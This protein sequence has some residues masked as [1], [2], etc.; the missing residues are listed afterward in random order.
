MGDLH[1]LVGRTVSHY[2]ILEKL[3]GGGMGVV[4]KAL[5]TKL[6]RMV[7]L[8]FLPPHLSTRAGA[9]ARFIHEAKAA[10]ALDHTNICT[11]YDIDE[12]DSGQLFIVMACYA[13][14]TLKKKIERG[15]LPVEDAL[16]YALQVAEGLGRAHE[17]G[18]VHRDIKPANVLVTERGV[19]K[20]VDF[21]IAKVL[22]R[23]QLTQTGATVGTVSYM[24]PEQARGE[25]VDARSDLWSLG[26][27]LYERLTGER[28][29]KGDYEQAVIYSILNVD[30]E[31]LTALRPAVPEALAQVV[32]KMLHKEPDARYQQVDDMRVDLTA[33]Q[34]AEGARIS[35]T[36]YRTAEAAKTASVKPRVLF[37]GLALFMLLAMAAVFYLMRGDEPQGAVEIERKRLVVLPFENIGP[38]EDEYFADGLTDEI[39][40]RLALVYGLGVISRASAVQYKNTNKTSKQIKEELD[41]DY[42]LAGTVGWDKSSDGMSRLH[43][44]PQLIRTSDDTHVWAERYD[45]ELEQLFDIQ[46]DIAEQVVKQL[47]IQLM[48]PARQALNAKPTRNLEAYDY[49]LRGNEHYRLGE[50]FSDEKELDQAVEM[51]QKAIEL[52][53][54]FAQAYL[55]LAYTHSWLCYTNDQTDERRAKARAAIDKA[56]EIQPD[57]PYVQMGLVSYYIYCL[58]DYDRA[59]EA[60]EN[61]R[62]AIPSATPYMMATILR[63]QGKWQESV[64]AMEET[65]ALNPNWAAPALN[66]AASYMWLRQYR[67]A[68]QWYDRALSIRPGYT[69][70]P[71][72]KYKNHLLWKGSAEDLRTSLQTIQRGPF[73][74]FQLHTI[75]LLERR[76]QE[77]LAHCTA[78]TKARHFKG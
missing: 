52:D 8:K 36:K 2:Q 64:A 44:T 21:G 53:P 35:R 17:E 22:A 67:E 58:E 73:I 28:P 72:F 18:I 41:V 76:F 27:V 9:K 26:V 33:L 59:L 71:I 78:P 66:L 74:N 13:G 55:R 1:Q 60:F 25:G 4:Y 65:V 24:S 15:P 16:D 5:D 29:F 10:S 3:G 38:P 40:S 63:R 30:P 37:G 68:D 57:L 49:F 11:V 34:N 48:E 47:D 14:E 19:V 56:I 45:R 6:D 46:S 32:L 62:K 12:T 39:R 43:V 50:E 23:T 54:D 42:I 77:A 70:P 61:L 69:W 75:N 51:Y 7:A 31:P 20:I